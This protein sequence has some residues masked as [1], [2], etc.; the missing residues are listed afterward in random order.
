MKRTALRL[1]S[2][3][4][5][6]AMTNLVYNRLVNPQVRKLRPHE[7]TVLDQST[8]ET[9][10]FQDFDIQLYR[11]PGGEERVFL[12]HGWEGQAGNFAELIQRL[13]AANY[14]VIAFDGPSHGFSSRGGTSLFE[15]TEL[16]GELLAKFEAKKL[17][18]HSF[19]GVAGTGAL[20]RNRGLSVDKYALLTTPDKFSDRIDE[21]AAR[22]GVSEAVKA[23]L[24]AR[25]EQESGLRVADL[26]VSNFVRQINV[27][28]ALIIHD[29]NDRVLP[30]EQSRNVQMNWPNCELLEVEG[31]GH[32]KILRTGSVLDRV[33]EFLGS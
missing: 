19:G 9:I 17:V 32:F 15:F 22:V 23:R 31:T 30:I 5:P 6:G 13:L 8:R 18:S 25:L 28:Q 20:W 4:F 16:V 1:L 3:L 27:A 11:W 21:L 12:I 24:I 26:S 2:T 10:R 33:V 14:S 7:L 29:R